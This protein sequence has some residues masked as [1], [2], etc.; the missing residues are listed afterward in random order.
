[1]SCHGYE[2]VMSALCTRPSSKVLHSSLN[3][4]YYPDQI[5]VF[6]L[7]TFFYLCKVKNNFCIVNNI[8]K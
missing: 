1:M 2:G 4:Y 5:L 8:S 7:G 3:H 6:L